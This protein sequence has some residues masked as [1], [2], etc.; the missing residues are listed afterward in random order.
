MNEQKQKDRERVVKGQMR[1]DDFKEA[2]RS[3]YKVVPN[4]ERFND[5]LK[6]M[7]QAEIGQ[8]KP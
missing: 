5:L 6:R 8:A 4:E 3:Q 7:E 1:R 2:F